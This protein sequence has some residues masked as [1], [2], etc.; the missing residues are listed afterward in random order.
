LQLAG[1]ALLVEEHF[2]KP[3]P[4]TFVF[5]TIVDAVV[6]VPMTVE[7]REEVHSGLADLQRM[8]RTET[9]PNPTPMRARCT[10]CEYR[11]FCADVF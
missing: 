7:L 8:L 2:Q 6:R 9:F 1:Y 3:V 5:L 11:N 10:D 4:A